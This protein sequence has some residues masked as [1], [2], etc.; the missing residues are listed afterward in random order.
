MQCACTIPSSVSSALQY[1]STLSHKPYVFREKK[2][3]VNKMCFDFV[4]KFVWNISHSKKE[5]TRY[6]QKCI[7]IFMW[8]TPYSCPVLMIPEFSPRI[9][10]KSSNT[11]FRENS[12]RGSR[13]ASCGRTDMTKLTVAL[14]NF[15]QSD[16][17]CNH[18]FQFFRRDTLGSSKHVFELCVS[19]F[20][21][22]GT[23]CF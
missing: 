20:N 17:K 4:C 10:E 15:A 7:L 16:Y 3:A 11:K 21:F 23:R 2:S 9:Y 14:R 8:S 19:P 18:P 13:V 5:W 6:D 1:F 22:S 12:S